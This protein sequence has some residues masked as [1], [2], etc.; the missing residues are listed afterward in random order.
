MFLIN[1]PPH[2]FSCAPRFSPREGLI[3]K[4]RP[5]IC[6][7]PYPLVV[8][9]VLVFST[10][11]QVFDL[12]TSYT[13]ISLVGFLDIE[14]MRIIQSENILSDQ[15]HF[16]KGGFTYLYT[17]LTLSTPILSGLSHISMCYH[18]TAYIGA[19]IL[20][21]YPSTLLFRRSLRSRLTLRR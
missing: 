15:A 16:D 10:I 3:P 13:Y 19:G 1:S 14:T 21:S 7:V 20:T 6:Q 4:L 12:G 9:I 11:L 17:S 2:I 18:I 8:S 5:L